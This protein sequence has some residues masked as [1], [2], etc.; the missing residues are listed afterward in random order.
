MPGRSIRFARSAR[1]AALLLAGALLVG[2]AQI[3][4]G[5]YG[6]ERL[7]FEGVEQVDERALRACL[8]TRQRERAGFDLGTTLADPSCNEPPFTDRALQVRLWT[9]PWT[10]WPLYDGTLFEQDLARVERWYAARGFHHARVTSVDID[11]PEAAERD[12]IPRPDPIPAEA[13]PDD[14]DEGAERVEASPRCEGEGCPVRVRVTIEEGA[15]TQVVAVELRGDDALPADAREALREALGLQPG[16]R[17]DEARFDATEAALRDVLAEHGHARAEVE[18]LARVDRGAREA[19]LVYALEP[20]PVCRFGEVRVE[21]ARSERNATI[22][23]EAALVPTGERYDQTVLREAQRAVFGLGAFRAVRVE[24]RIPDQGEVV[25][26]AITVEPGREHH[27][28]VGVG[29][30]SGTSERG[31]GDDAFDVPLWDAHLSAYYENRDFLGGLRK[32]R[33]EERPRLVVL[34]SFPRAEQP[35][36]GNVASATFRQPGFLEPRTELVASLRWEWGPDPFDTFFR[37][38]VDGRLALERHFFDQRLFATVGLRSNFYRVPDGELREDG[39]P[40]P[41]DSHLMFVHERLRLDLRDDG[42][43]PHRGALLQVDAQQAGFVPYVLASSWDYVR[44]VPE[45]RVYAPLPRG[46]TIAARFQLGFFF[47]RGADQGLDPLSRELGPRSQRLRGGGASSHRG[48]LPGRLGD[49]EEGG[50]RRWLGSIE[51]R[52]PLTADTGL[53]AFFDVGD[54]SR[55]PSFRFDHPQAAAG[56]GFRYFTVLGALRVDLAVRL[57]GMQVFGADERSP[58]AVPT[59]VSFGFFDFPGAFHVTLGEAF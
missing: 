1:F 16:D 7:A 54:V 12:V 18:S 37:H 8:G 15:P 35:R 45:A 6:V 25:D 14:E 28:G 52:T 33:L 42:Q 26:V 36:F 51:L 24:P 59:N 32:L 50:T 44:L 47:L 9:W 20:G 2:C 56:L 29:L 23:R 19:R 5:R 41:A 21:G 3:P 39:S 38:E 4:R 48:F 13:Q 58:G 10:E 30:Q 46:L 55:A 43:R 11:P 57:P 27:Y 31:V 49:G 17:F 40:P 22:V 53:V 34:Q